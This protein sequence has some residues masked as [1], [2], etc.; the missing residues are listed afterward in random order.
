MT[1]VG[2][3]RVHGRLALPLDGFDVGVM[4]LSDRSIEQ[5]LE[6]HTAPVQKLEFVDDGRQLISAGHDARVFVWQLEPSLE[7]N[8]ERR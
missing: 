1:A 3:D 5:R 7:P 8:L 4:Q 2:V 6:G